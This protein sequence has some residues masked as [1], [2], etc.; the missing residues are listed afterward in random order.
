[1]TELQKDEAFAAVQERFALRPEA[2]TVEKGSLHL[3]TDR[4]LALSIALTADRP[5]APWNC[6]IRCGTLTGKAKAGRPD[7]ALHN[8]LVHLAQLA[9]IRTGDLLIALRDAQTAERELSIASSMRR[10]E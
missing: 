8:A 7:H 5:G 10:P 9:A 1:M 6:T 2:I 4:G 3:T